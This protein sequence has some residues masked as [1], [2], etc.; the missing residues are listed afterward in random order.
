[1]GGLRRST[2]PPSS[3]RSGG[4]GKRRASASRGQWPASSHGHARIARRVEGADGAE[5]PG[6]A[7]GDDAFVR[8]A[9]PVVRGVLRVVPAALAADAQEQGDAGGRRRA[10][11]H[12]VPSEWSLSL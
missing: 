10:L 11:K 7:A 2:V 8:T 9:V 5:R 1:C 4:T 3:P 12:V 6:D